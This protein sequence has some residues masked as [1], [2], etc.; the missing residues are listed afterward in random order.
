MW[1]GWLGLA[2]L[3]PAL[4]SAGASFIRTILRFHIPLVEPDMQSSR[5]RLPEETSRVRSLSRCT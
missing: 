4:S 2:Y 1:R 5:I 3:F